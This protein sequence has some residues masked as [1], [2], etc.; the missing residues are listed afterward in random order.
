MTIH[1]H[2]HSPFEPD[3]PLRHRFAIW[4]FL[5]EQAPIAFAAGLLPLW[6]G[7][8][9][10]PA[11]LWL[12]LLPCGFM[13]AMV[14]LDAVAWRHFTHDRMG[15]AVACATPACLLASAFLLVCAQPM[16]IGDW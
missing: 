5:L 11:H 6:S 4:I 9:V 1:L 12:P 16:V 13:F 14:A 8:L 15:A 3:H 2:H 7:S 10:S